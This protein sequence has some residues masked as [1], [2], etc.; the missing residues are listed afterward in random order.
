MQR[1]AIREEKGFS[2][3]EVTVSLAI[4]AIGLLA[5]GALQITATRTATEAQHLTQANLLAN[6]MMGMLWGAPSLSNLTAYHDLDTRTPPSGADRRA[7]NAAMWRR[8]LEGA[9]PEGRGRVSVCLCP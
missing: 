8:D 3:I 9:L 2:L 1:A 6:E 4:F 5:L 7:Q